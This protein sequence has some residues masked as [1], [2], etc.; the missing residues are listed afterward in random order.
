MAAA[1]VERTKEAMMRRLIVL[2]VFCCGLCTTQLQSQSNLDKTKWTAVDGGWIDE[3]NHDLICNLPSNVSVTGG[4]LT[5]TAKSVPSG[6]SCRGGVDYGPAKRNFTG[7]TIYT[8]SFNFKYGTISA[9]IKSAGYGVHSGLLWMMGSGCQNIMYKHSYWCNHT[10]P[11]PNNEIDIAEIKP[12]SEP[13]LTVVSQNFFNSEGW[14]DGSGKTT[15]VQANWHVY[16]LVW[17]P[18]SLKFQIDGVTTTTLK[19][20]V[21]SQEMFPIISEE[22]EKDAGGAPDPSTFPQ[23][24]Q[25]DY[26]RVWDAKGKKIFDDEFDDLKGTSR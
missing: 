22:I 5:L 23:F 11:E 1:C 16:T 3:P 25:V 6:V 15:N 7:G 9:R 17:T 20:D 24:I 21:P 19:K 14:H 12:A 18:T 13:T 2:A 10:W 8:T 4:I 26:V